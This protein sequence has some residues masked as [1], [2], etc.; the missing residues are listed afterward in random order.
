MPWMLSRLLVSVE[1]GTNLAAELRRA[2]G[3]DGV[4]DPERLA[5]TTLGV[6]RHAL[7]AGCTPDQVRRFTDFFV[8]VVLGQETYSASDR[9]LGV[10][11]RG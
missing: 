10:Q 8:G 2:A 3:P 11:A 7:R 4:H 6:M 5:L 1:G 9:P